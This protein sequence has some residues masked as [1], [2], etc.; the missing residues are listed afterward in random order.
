MTS[1]GIVETGFKSKDID[2]VQEEL[3]TDQENAFGPAINTA[4]ASVFGQMNSIFGDKIVEMWELGLA[5][6]RAG[7]PDNALGASLD[8]VAALTGAER[9]PATQSTST[10]TLNLDTGTVLN[11]GRVVSVSASGNRFTTDAAAQNFTGAKALVSV[12]AT[13]E[14]YGPIVA[15]ARTV[16]TIETPVSGWT[17]QAAVVSPNLEPFGLANGQ[18][19]EIEADQGTTQTVTFI[20]GD[21]GDIANATAQEVA[22]AINANTA[23]LEALD[24]NGAVF[25]QSDTDGPGSAIQVIGGT[26]NVALGFSTDLFAGLNELDAELG[27]NLETDLDFRFRREELIRL[28]GASTFE[29]MRAALRD[30]SNV[31][32][33]QQVFIFENDTLVT[34]ANGIPGKA[35]E[36]VALGGLDQ[37]IA[38]TIFAHKPLGIES[39]RDPG[40]NGVTVVVNDS[41]GNPRD[42][43]FT[44]AT[45]VLEYVEIDVTANLATFG[46]GDL[47]AGKQLV[48][49]AIAQRGRAQI[50]GETVYIVQYKCSVVPPPGVA[51]VGVP[52]VVDVTDIKIENVFPPSNTV[53]IALTIREIAKFDTSRIVVNVASV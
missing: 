42:T 47:E 28:P 23:G 17:A 16:D 24:A 36:V 19:F 11:V 15:N 1:F 44:R 22:D 12:A 9:L 39:Y 7:D 51:E 48:K 6:Y 40:P 5:V 14:E 38:E 35:F 53:N 50:I 2:T 41:Q 33:L 49:D 43:N 32:G 37:E 4:P 52:G 34:D 8:T 10:L 31:A 27:R 13:A 45:E 21:F 18:T 3:R 30:T 20:T 29:A 25:I 46:G 26:G